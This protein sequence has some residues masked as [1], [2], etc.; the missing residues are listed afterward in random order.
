M[1]DISEPVGVR[2]ASLEQPAAVT[3]RGI[4]F[5]VLLRTVDFTDREIAA[6]FVVLTAIT[7]IPVVFYPRPP[8]S[9]YI[10]DLSRMHIIATAGSDPELSKFYDVNWQIIPNLM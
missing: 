2:T 8:L 6:L 3:R 9:D 10:N 4:G 5:S 7:V 1:V